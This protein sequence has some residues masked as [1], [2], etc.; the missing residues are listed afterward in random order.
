MQCRA[1]STG[2][3]CCPD[4][5]CCHSLPDYQ[6]YYAYDYDTLQYTTNTD[7]TTE[8][9]HDYYANDTW[10]DHH[11]QYREDTDHDDS[12]KNV[13]VKEDILLDVLYNKD[14][15]DVPSK[16]RVGPTGFEES[17]SL[18]MDKNN[19]TGNG[20]EGIDKTL[21]NIVVKHAD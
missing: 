12:D 16:S 5:I 9:Y 11:Q 19:T 2:Q 21:N 1:W 4:S 8:G 13:D 6:D 10:Q 14:N 20:N 7:S 17:D 18:S 15:E 3:Y